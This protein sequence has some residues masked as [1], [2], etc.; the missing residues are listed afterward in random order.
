MG[1]D[2][3]ESQHGRFWE[4]Q[5]VKKQELIRYWT[6]LLGYVVILTYLL[7]MPPGHEP[8]FW[9]ADKIF[10]LFFFA[11]LGGLWVR[12]FHPVQS[13]WSAQKCIF[14]ALLGG[15]LY[16]GLTEIGQG[17]TG[18]RS[19]EWADFLMDSLGGALGG[20]GY[21]RLKQWFTLKHIM[22]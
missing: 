13:H 16:G 18:D 15:L 6:P 5:N 11:V 4:I 8:H 9:L 20:Y 3:G 7:F 22:E 2:P 12:T 10:H 17:F 14:M 19:A 1:R 21:F